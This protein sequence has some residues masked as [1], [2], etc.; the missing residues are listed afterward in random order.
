[1]LYGRR[2]QRAGERDSGV[3]DGDVDASEALDGRG[4]RALQRVEVGDVGLEGHG[5]IAHARRVL[6]QALGLEPDERHVGAPRVKPLGARGADS[7]RRTRDEHRSPVH[8]ERRLGGAG[9]RWHQ[10][11]LPW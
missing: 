10:P 6:L 3:G 1:M 7:A 2:R 5:A 4:D 8:V 9:S 11:S